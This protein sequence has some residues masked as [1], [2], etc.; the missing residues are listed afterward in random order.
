MSIASSMSDVASDFIHV[1][2]CHSL[3]RPEV[4]SCFE[5]VGR[6]QLPEKT[7][8]YLHGVSNHF[9][10]SE[11]LQC[12]DGVSNLMDDSDYCA[13]RDRP[14]EAFVYHTAALDRRGCCVL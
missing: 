9:V 10:L 13:Q 1:G 5:F 6:C 7:G 2:G 14:T 4:A 12:E 3:R 11:L 8:N